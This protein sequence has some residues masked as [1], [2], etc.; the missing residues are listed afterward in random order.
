MAILFDAIVFGPVKSRRFGTSLGINLLP[1][2]NKVCNFNCVYCECGWTNL[3]AEK[4]NYFS[5]TDIV[6]AVET[7][8][9]K[10]SAEGNE[11]SSITF[12]GNGE[13]TM[14]PRFKEIV[15]KVKKLRDHYLP[16]IQLVVLSNAVLLGNPKVV[17]GLRFADL[18]VLKLDAGTEELFQRLNKPLGS[19]PLS[20]FIEKLKHFDGPLILQSIFLTG[21]H[22][23]H[24]IDNTVEKELQAWLHTVKYI[25]PQS[26]MIYSLDR[27]TPAGGIQAVPKSTLD[28]ICERVNTLG[29]PCQAFA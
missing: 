22:E 29:I 15:E 23:G 2:E 3:K 9:R 17:E 28:A 27:P 10:I 5:Y 13:P 25:S 26:V 12:A 8:F 4:I 19:K 18:C 24:S 20:W 21:S 16:G 11:I 6:E 7:A 1:L 14:H